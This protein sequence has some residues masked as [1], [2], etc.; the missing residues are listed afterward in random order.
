[1][2]K[3]RICAGDALELCRRLP[4][5]SVHCVVTSPPYWGLRDYG[6]DGQWGLEKTP[7]EYVEHLVALFEEIR[8]VLRADGTVWLNL[9]DNY[10]RSPK[11]GIK[12]EA[13]PASNKT[14]LYNRQ[15]D[16]GNC[17]PAI[18][19]GLKPKDL[20]G[21][22]WRVAFALQAA[23]WWLR[24]DIIWAKSNPMPESCTDRPSSSH[25]YIFLLTKSARYFYDAEAVKEPHSAPFRRS[26]TNALRG[27][28]EI[29]PRG[30]LMTVDE[31]SYDAAGRNLRS[32]WTIPTQPYPGSHYATFPER[33]PE[34]CIKAGT[35]ERGVCPEC[36]APWERVVERVAKERDDAGRTAS[37]PEQR[38]G[39][40]PPPERGWETETSTIGWRPTCAC[41]C[42]ETVP[43]IVLDPF[44]GSGTT[45]VVAIRMGRKFVGFDLAGGDVD[46]GGFTPQDRLDAAAKGVTLK[47]HLAGQGALFAGHEI[48]ARGVV[49]HET[50]NVSDKG[51]RH[52]MTP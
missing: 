4:D 38:F 9:G 22:P 19:R 50:G 15:A 36:G 32:V 20:V 43:A 12:F 7:E 5:A 24:R 8:R 34:T 52:W 25:E 29:R 51:E 11:K 13:K 35:S 39:K 23:G 33:L 48:S 28:M 37:L 17:G 27:Q 44:A 49:G 31:Q 6:Q 47:E 26:G 40:T 1:M 18:P 3:N 21:M 42:D 41:G 14:Y 30:N 16:E 45:G 46:H 2:F 10:A